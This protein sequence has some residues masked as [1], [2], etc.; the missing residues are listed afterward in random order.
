[1]SMYRTWYMHGEEF[2]DN[3]DNNIALGSG[4]DAEEDDLDD[5][6]QMVFDVAGPN[7]N[8]REE[9]PNAEAKKFYDL[10]KAFLVIQ[11]LNSRK[12]LIFSSFQSMSHFVSSFRCAP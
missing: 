11:L 10:L 1:M 8:P 4:E 6:T 5:M 2:P 9:A 3:L 7:W 12:T